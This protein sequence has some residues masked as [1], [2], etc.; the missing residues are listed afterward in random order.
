MLN[1]IKIAIAIGYTILLTILSL[2]SVHNIPGFGTDYDDK[3][4]HILAYFLLTAIWYFAIGGE[5]NKKQIWQLAL[6]CTA[7]GIILEA[8][9]GK[10]TVNR[11]GDLL[12]IIAN[13]IGVVIATILIIRRQRKLS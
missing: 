5:I 8:I 1:K 4:Y 11:M 2:I 9:Q 13:I 3:L 12:D 6:Y 7:F 10:L